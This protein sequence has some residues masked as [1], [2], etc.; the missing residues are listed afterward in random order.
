MINSPITINNKRYFIKTTS[1][2][3]PI[4]IWEQ[5]IATGDYSPVISLL[6]SGFV[7]DR[8]TNAASIDGN[9]YY[10]PEDGILRKI[11]PVNNNT[12]EV[13]TSTGNTIQ[14]Q[15]GLTALN[16][17]L[18][19]NKG[20]QLWKFDLKTGQEALVTPESLAFVS[21]ITNVNGTIY[22][23]SYNNQTS[24]ALLWKLDKQTDLPVIVTS[25][26]GIQEMTNINGTLYLR[27]VDDQQVGASIWQIKPDD[28]TV[29]VALG[30]NLPTLQNFNDQVYFQHSTSNGS[31]INYVVKFDPATRSSTEIATIPDINVQFIQIENVGD[32]FYGRTSSYLGQDGALWKLDSTTKT[33]TKIEL[34]A[35]NGVSHPGYLTK[36]D[37]A[38]Y[39]A[40][41][42]NST[43]RELWKID[44]SNTNP[45]LVQDRS[46]GDSS[47]EPNILGYENGKL[48]IG[49]YR[50][51]TN[52]SRGV[53]EL[54]TTTTPVFNY[55]PEAGQI[56][57]Q[58]TGEGQKFSLTLPYGQFSNSNYLDPLTYS[59]KTSEGN[60]L[61]AW[62]T[63]DPVTTAFSGTPNATD[64]GN[65]NIQVTATDTGGLTASSKFVVSVIPKPT[66]TVVIPNVS[67]EYN[68]NNVKSGTDSTPAE[69]TNVGGTIYFTANNDLNGRELWK[70][71][72][73]S[74]EP[75]LIDIKVGS[76]SS[77]PKNLINVNGTLYFT[78][79]EEVFTTGNE[80]LWK[81][82]PNATSPVVAKT[83]P[84][85]VRNL[86]TANGILYFSLDGYEGKA[87]ETL[88]KIE[89]SGGACD[90]LKIKIRQ[91]DQG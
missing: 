51:T 80:E 10:T 63:F 61:P 30:G 28:Q 36:V 52:T 9:I 68:I 72:P 19:F 29:T 31:L 91:A 43:G 73:N 40:A 67:A 23:T 24:R 18:Y 45:V 83:F 6:R 5:D 53:L 89:S 78:T 11:D 7:S 41:D 22:F 14:V 37:G 74:G 84:G 3:H 75:T 13:K 35:G 66:R 12:V 33:A 49:I 77:N 46:P 39:F 4:E 47:S 81:L 48:Y 26:L 42:T 55:A 8:A 15:S 21:N 59:A 20:E 16:D 2:E 60:Q 79:S 50:P 70:I 34:E 62:L 56:S 65:F 69:L 38:I 76:E 64:T 85:G 32:T 71:D 88:F 87:V 58:I 25:F 82:E 44:S 27:A 57:D 1:D 86:V 54:A 17:V 90:F